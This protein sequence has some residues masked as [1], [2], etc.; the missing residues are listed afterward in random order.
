MDFD[1][2][3]ASICCVRLQS[4]DQSA[5]DGEAHLQLL[6]EETRYIEHQKRLTR[7]EHAEKTDIAP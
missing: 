3:I 2:K 4:S 5:G 6:G 7:N 1:S